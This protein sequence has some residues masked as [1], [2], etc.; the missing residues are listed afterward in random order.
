MEAVLVA[1]IVGGLAILGN[2]LM[3][4]QDYARQDEVARRVTDAADKLAV[5]NERVALATEVTN[6]KLDEVH[7]IVNQQRTDMVAR[8]DDLKAAL[9]AAGLPVPPDAK[10]EPAP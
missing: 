5:Q 2:W 1:L 4:R 8:I 9:V 7:T 3:K 10:R 6:T